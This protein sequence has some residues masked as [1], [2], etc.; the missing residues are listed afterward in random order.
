MGFR[1]AALIWLAAAA[2]SAESRSA[3]PYA[4]RGIEAPPPAMPSSGGFP[5]E[6]RSDSIPKGKPI[7]RSGAYLGMALGGMAL[8][9][10]LIV[11][12]AMSHEA[13]RNA[14]RTLEKVFGPAPGSEQ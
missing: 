4:M 7:D 14:D 2:A 13:E 10:G 1:I 5:A 3:S 8:C 11:V 6:D 12:K 9:A